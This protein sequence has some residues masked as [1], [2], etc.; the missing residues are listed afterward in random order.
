MNLLE[1]I[2]L[3]RHA[4]EEHVDPR[5]IVRAVPQQNVFLNR[6]VVGSVLEVA[7]RSKSDWLRSD[8]V[9]NRL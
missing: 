6:Q 5:G 2:S 3:F 1:A 8:T 9:L 7:N 4:F